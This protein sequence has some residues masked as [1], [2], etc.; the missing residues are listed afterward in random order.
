M[1]KNSY[2]NNII[3]TI[4]SLFCIIVVLQGCY[5]FDGA[6]IP[7]HI[8]TIK[9]ATVN[10]NSGYGDPRYKTRLTNVLIEEFQN[11]NSLELAERK[12]DGRLTVTITSISDRTK[13]L[14]PGEIEKERQIVVSVSAEYYD[15][16]KRKEFWKKSFSD[17]Q[18]YELA[19]IQTNRDIAIN[20]ALEN[21]ADDLLLAVVSGW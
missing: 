1:K 9:V 4:S 17:T 16:V 3:L 19:D 2:I 13:T 7:D 6:S 12:G 10:D 15:T 18:V 8:K 21:I 14:N 11:D 20:A 5:S